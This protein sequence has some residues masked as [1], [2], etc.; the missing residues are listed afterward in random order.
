[1]YN[2]LV[3]SLLLLFSTSVE[4]DNDYVY[5]SDDYK[6]MMLDRVNNLRAEGCY[7]GSEFMSPVKAVVWDDMLYKSALS[8]AKEMKDK[9]FFSHFSANGLDIGDRLDD[10]GYPWQVAGENLGEGQR[11]FREVMRDWIE[12]PSHCRMLMNPKVEEMG[13]ARHSRFWVQHFGKKLPKG[14]RRSKRK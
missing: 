10:F 8:H 13:V 6:E 9:R 7:C 5:P 12:S 2:T 3:I 4:S 1:M 14:S 11:S